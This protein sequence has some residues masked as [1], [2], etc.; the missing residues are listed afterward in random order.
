MSLEIFF[1]FTPFKMSRLIL[2]K[3]ARVAQTAAGAAWKV[4]RGRPRREV[5][6]YVCE[7]VSRMGPVFVKF[8]QVMSARGDLIGKDFA[9]GLSLLQDDVYR[10]P[11]EEVAPIVER[12]S[13]FA[14]V[15]AAAPPQR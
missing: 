7:R 12:V 14:D 11:P 6:D 5:S 8:G 3:Y 10:I 2:D 15:D 9:E 13:R 1:S 4:A